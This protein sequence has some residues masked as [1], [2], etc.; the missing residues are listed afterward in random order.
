MIEYRNGT[1]GL[2]ASQLEGFFEGWPNPPS[3]ATHLRLLEGSSH[4]V[5]A[6][7]EDRVVGFVTALSDGVQNAYLPLLEVLASHRGRGLGRELVRRV[8]AE[9]GP[10]YS[11]SLHCDPE[12]EAFYGPL[13]LQPLGGMAIRNY[14]AQSGLA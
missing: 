10:L 14:E 5:L 1:G 13:G 7:D 9:I 11:I 8:L 2:E 4:V 3:P 6:L 12:L